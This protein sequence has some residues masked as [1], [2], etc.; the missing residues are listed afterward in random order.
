MLGSEKPEFRDIGRSL[1]GQFYRQNLYSGLYLSLTTHPR[2]FAL[3]PMGEGGSFQSPGYG[4]FDAGLSS[5]AILN[6][7]FPE[8]VKVFGNG[9]AYPELLELLDQW[10]ALGHPSIHRLKIRA[11]SEAPEYISGGSWVIPKQSDYTWVLSW[12]I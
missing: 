6:D 3:M 12:E 5:A 4:V 9:P 10:D 7:R 8:Q 2:V 1:E 11:L